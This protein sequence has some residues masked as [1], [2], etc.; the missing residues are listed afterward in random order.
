MKATVT[1]IRND[2]NYTIENIVS[3]QYINNNLVITTIEVD[4]TVATRHYNSN[5]VLVNIF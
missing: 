4:G 3:V 2:Y 1:N 5:E